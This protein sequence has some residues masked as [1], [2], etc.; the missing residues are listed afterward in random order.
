MLLKT[1]ITEL[2]CWAHAR[3]KFCERHA[4]N[5]SSIAR[6]ALERIGKLYEIEQRG[7]EM[8]CAERQE[9]RPREA[10]PLLDALFEWLWQTRQKVAE[11]SGT[12]KAMDYSLKYWAAPVQEV[13][14][15]RSACRTSRK[16]P[17]SPSIST[18]VRARRSR[19]ATVHL[20]CNT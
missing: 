5:P 14:E 16:L 17:G 19:C 4:A 20:S 12:A 10:R 8:N 11:G 3:R 13:T 6:E 7:R 9:L 18:R 1:G 2:G 15:E